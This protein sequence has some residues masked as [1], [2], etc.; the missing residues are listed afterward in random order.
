MYP[1]DDY[2]VDAKDQ[3]KD[4]IQT[5]RWLPGDKSTMFAAAG[6]D[7]KIRFY[8]LTQSSGYNSREKLE[9]KAV[10]DM[11]APVLALEWI[12]GTSLLA[13]LADG[14]LAEINTQNGNKSS[15]AKIDSP[16]LELKYFEDNQLAVLIVFTGDD[17]I[18]F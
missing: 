15:I 2:T 13:G 14:N 6:W 10:V 1:R 11:G 8:E 9:C 12:S 5:I 17:R 16:I 3:P 18:F 7:G 4:S